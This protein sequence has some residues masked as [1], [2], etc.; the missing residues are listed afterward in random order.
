MAVADHRV[1]R[2]AGD[3]NNLEPGAQD[4][5]GV[6]NLTAV[7]STRQAD[8]GDQQIDLRVR[9]Q[10]FQPRRP[11]AS[12]DRGIAGVGENLSDQHADGGLVVDD[13]HHVAAGLIGHAGAAGFVLGGKGLV[14]PK[15]A[16]QIQ[17]HRCPVRDFGIHAHLPARLAREPVDHRQPQAGAFAE[18]L[19]G[20]EGVENPL[21]QI[22]RHADAAVG[23]AQRHVLARR[24][25]AFRGSSF[26]EPF[27][28]GFDGEPAAV[29]HRVAG[30]DAQIQQRVFELV[31][32]HQGQPQTAGTDHLH[33]HTRSDGAPHQVGH[34]L[35]QAV[36][37]GALGVERL[38]PRE[39]QQAMRQGR[40]ALEPALGGV[41]VAVDRIE[42]ALAQTDLQHLQAAADG[43]EQIVEVVR[44]PAGELADRFH[45]LRLAQRVFGVRQRFG[46]LEFFGDVAA[47]AVDLVVF[48]DRQ[49]RD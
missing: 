25:V 38:P 9:L 8:V 16:R 4:A 46:A 12:L 44:Q 39:R 26:I 18:R 1:L 34:A 15:A 27:V 23:H 49:P 10:H 40:R 33:H 31:G 22:A 14:R 21:D 17:A 24:Q 37:I 30:V 2:I 13:Q 45:F 7:Q 11:V 5:R 19:G 20:E 36:E 43:G 29:G 35:D 28:G 3:E 42:A 48:G 47:G 6:G 32:V 41:D